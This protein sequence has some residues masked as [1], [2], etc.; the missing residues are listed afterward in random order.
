MVSYVYFIGNLEHKSV[1]IGKANTVSKRLKTIQTSA[2]FALDVLYTFQCKTE[3]D[4]FK[5]ENILH[6]HMFN[7]NTHGEWFEMEQSEVNKLVKMVKRDHGDLLTNQAS[8]NRFLEAVACLF[9]IFA[10]LW[11]MYLLNDFSD[12]S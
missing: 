9:Y 11:I 10:S 4:A 6:R 7:L 2:P 12:L 5:L 3:A 8:K 1:K